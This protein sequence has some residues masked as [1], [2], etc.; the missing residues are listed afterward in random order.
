MIVAVADT[1]SKEMKRVLET[2]AEMGLTIHYRIPVPGC[3]C[4]PES[5]D[6]VWTVLYD[7]LCESFRTGWAAGDEAA[8]GS[9]RSAGRLCIFRNIDGGR[10]ADDQAGVSRTDF[11]CTETGWT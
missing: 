3:Q 1:Q 8:A 4:E 10:R 6:A 9:G 5:P 2:L 7:Y 11:L